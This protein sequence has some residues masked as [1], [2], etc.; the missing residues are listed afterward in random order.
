MFLIFALLC[1][2]GID[3]YINNILSCWKNLN[4]DYQPR[5]KKLR[6]SPAVDTT[7]HL[8]NLPTEMFF[9]ILKYIPVR[10]IGN[11]ALTANSF[12]YRVSQETW[13]LGDDFDIVLLDNS[14]V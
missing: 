6:I 13:E 9:A 1:Q 2:V 14:L 10:D 8:E 5:R 7:C 11:L 3:K 4:M 12:R